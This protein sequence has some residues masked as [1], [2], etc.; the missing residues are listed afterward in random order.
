[1]SDLLYKII[2][3]IGLDKLYIFLKELA[4]FYFKPLYFY[5][6]FFRKDF[7]EQLRQLISYSII[8]IL[9][10]YILLEDVSIK[11]LASSLI[12]EMTLLL[13][14]IL[15]LFSSNYLVYQI[16]KK[17]LK[18]RNVVF[19]AMLTKLLYAPFQLAFFGLFV[20]WENYNYLFFQNLVYLFIHVYF[21]FFSGRIF[22]QR[23]SRMLLSCFLTFL[24][25]NTLT[26]ILDKASI[27]NFSTFES[28]YYEDQILKERIDKTQNFPYPYTTP[29]NRILVKAKGVTLSYFVYADPRDSVATGSFADSEAYEKDLGIKIDSINA[30]LPT[31]HSKRN[32]LLFLRLKSLYASI[33]SLIKAPVV[34]YTGKDIQQKRKLI[35]ADSTIYDELTL[36]VPTHFSSIPHQL[37][38][39]ELQ[40]ET[41]SQFSMMPLQIASYYYVQN[42]FK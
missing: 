14:M 12:V 1:M 36:P 29:Y 28:P 26:W 11:E 24:L 31:L 21:F 17:L 19:F 20:K 22:N 18:L 38:Q 16:D 8:I 37:M 7:K 42:W 5:E 30:I 23:I 35:A 39:D 6:H 2:E 10:G 32:Q 13:S 15:T 33:D 3:N 25:M 9:L 34:E 41:L 4:T 27:D 40:L